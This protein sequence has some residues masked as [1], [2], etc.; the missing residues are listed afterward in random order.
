MK[1]PV[2]NDRCSYT[3]EV[4]GL[5]PPRGSLPLQHGQGGQGGG[6]GAATGKQEGVKEF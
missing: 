5:R 3:D 4:S 2:F 6:A 1:N